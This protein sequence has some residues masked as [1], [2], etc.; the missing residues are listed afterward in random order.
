MQRLV[1]QFQNAYSLSN[2]LVK[3]GAVD[4]T[5]MWAIPRGALAMQMAIPPLDRTS[6]DYAQFVEG[7]AH[8]HETL[9]RLV[10]RRQTSEDAELLTATC[11]PQIARVLTNTVDELHGADAPMSYTLESSELARRSL[12]ACVVD[13]FSSERERELEH[14]LRG[15]DDKLF[16]MEGDERETELQSI[17]DE[18]LEIRAQRSEDAERDPESLDDYASKTLSAEFDVLFES[19]ERMSIEAAGQTMVMEKR[20]LSTWRFISPSLEDDHVE[21]RVAKIF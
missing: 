7:A 2:Q 19:N 6:F 8:A 3:T 13:V 15:Y 9:N 10:Y 18:L 21:W 20:Q 1:K 17:T 11:T 5:L 12:R 14:T 4:A 16:H